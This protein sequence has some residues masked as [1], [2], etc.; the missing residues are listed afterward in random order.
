[1]GERAPPA[2]MG[3]RETMARELDFE[4]GPPQVLTSTGADAFRPRGAKARPLWTGVEEERDPNKRSCCTPFRLTVALPD[5]DGGSARCWPRAKF[6]LC[7]LLAAATVAAI[8][9]LSLVITADARR[10][11]VEGGPEGDGGDA[12]GGAAGLSPAPG[13]PKQSDED[14]TLAVMAGPAPFTVPPGWT[15]LWWDEFA[16]SSLDSKYW[17][18]DTG[19]VCLCVW[20]AC[21]Y[22]CGALNNPSYIE[23][24][25]I[26]FLS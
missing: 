1:M 6:A 14:G 19:C 15:A 22:I 12:S 10:R 4:A 20:G 18:I 25:N 5:D 24:Q 7:A 21:A 9:I 2:A 11:G 16:G 13:A 3:L 17:T 8:V 26:S 23:I